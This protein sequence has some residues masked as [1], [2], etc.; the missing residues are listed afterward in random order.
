MGTGFGVAETVLAG[1]EAE[2]SAVRRFLQGVVHGTAG[3]LLVTGEGGVGKTA[4][5][6]HGC[7]EFADQMTVLA[8]RCLPLTSMSVPFLALRS[9]LRD[10]GE[11]RPDA[12][13]T[14]TFET[15]ESI[16]SVP[17][18]LDAWLDAQCREQPVTLFVD[19]LQWADQSTLDVI[20]Y[21]VAGSRTRRLGLMAT[22]RMDEVGEGHP[23]HR[24]L[25]DVRRMPGTEELPLVPLGRQATAVQ[26]SGILGQPPHESLVE[27]VFSRT[28]GNAY[29]TRLLVAGIRPEARHIA[30]DM[31]ADLA[32]AVLR[33]WTAMSPPTRHLTRVV[34]M[35][36]MPISR[37]RL[38]RLADAAHSGVGVPEML[39]ESVE[40]GVLEPMQ[41][42][43][44]WFR[45]P[46]IAEALHQ[47][48]PAD[49]RQQWH[50]FFADDLQREY[51]AGMDRSVET[52]VAIADHL[53]ASGQLDDA[54]NWA[55]RAADAAR[56][57]GGNAE[58]LRLLTR[59]LAL[60]DEVHK[61]DLNRRELLTHL[62]SAAR[63][64][65]ADV[66]ELR[67]I[68][69]LLKEID[70]VAEPLPRADLLLRR[71][72]L[73]FRT[74]QSFWSVDEA[75]GIVLL[76]E[77]H[78][79]SAQ[80]ASALASLALAEN[81]ND[82]PNAHDHATQS[83]E[84]AS[85]LGDAK[86]LSYSLYV[87]G[88]VALFEGHNDRCMALAAR[89]A[90]LALETNDPLALVEAAIVEAHGVEYWTTRSFAESLQRRRLQLSEMKA[91]HPYVAILAGWE[92]SAWVATGDWQEGLGCLRVALGANPGPM[93]DVQARLVAAR[94]AVLQGRTREAR[95]HLDRADEI[96]QGASAFLPFEFDVVRAQVC[97]SEGGAADAF[98]AAMSGLEPGGV[99]P[100]LC[101]WLLPLAAR[102]LADLAALARD[103]GE[104]PRPHVDAVWSN[105]FL[106]SFE[107]WGSQPRH[108]TARSGR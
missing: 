51:A 56:T 13:V 27:D 85:R 66:D 10:L 77:K 62:I 31:P 105:V 30:S 5:A 32:G 2:T 61:S 58:M 41:D 18:L 28:C 48:M 74:G 35:G 104:N 57:A 40:A 53:H 11:S 1:R 6:E 25:A 49:E 84:I 44:Y 65:G 47:S 78:P 42:G 24:W 33:S 81:W 7:A 69:T 107:M 108:G 45:H 52:V 67:A 102:A 72:S 98:H 21:L 97:L 63:I 26:M 82:D 90:A 96:F 95:G 46:M 79:E 91:P 8:G 71:A 100:S 39:R 55:L 94:L 22:I 70:P 99:P 101:E 59:A 38:T 43:R 103:R 76:T 4:L 12:P 17:V 34:A 92:A 19:D 16:E 9:A 3:T 106:T 15:A 68:E 64:T 60:L 93:A 73:R 75:R 88:F 20:M 87:S 14:P 83:L 50:S 36:G 23:L 29:L 89:S 86:T 54:F 37:V 80:Y